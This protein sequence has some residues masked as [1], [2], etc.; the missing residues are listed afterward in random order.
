MLNSADKS[1]LFLTFALVGLLLAPFW[2]L[3][4]DAGQIWPKSKGELCWETRREGET[5]PSGMARL[6]ITN[7]FAGHYVVAGVATG[8]DSDGNPYTNIVHGNAELIGDSVMMTFVG[9]ERDSDALRAGIF[10]VV[11]DISTLDG[12]QENIGWEYYRV[13]GSITQ[14]IER[15]SL[16]LTDCP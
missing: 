9:S 3:D 10:N 1:C 16:K 4:S 6:G 13:S 12:D 15:G 5:E 8:T 11:L 7:I 2:V 14:E